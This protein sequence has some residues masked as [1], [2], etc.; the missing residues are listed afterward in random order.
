MWVLGADDRALPQPDYLA[1][2]KNLGPG[3][4]YCSRLQFCHMVF[5]LWSPPYAMR[6]LLAMWHEC[7]ITEQTRR[8]ALGCEAARRKQLDE[9]K[10]REPDSPDTDLE[11]AT[12][13]LLPPGKDEDEHR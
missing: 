9:A 5:R 1:I 10:T 2:L 7:V 12:V 4:R 8:Y 13:K 6:Y 3:G 11:Q